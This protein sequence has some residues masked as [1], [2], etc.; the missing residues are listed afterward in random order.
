MILIDDFE[1]AINSQLDKNISKDLDQRKAV[2][3][4][5]DE[6]QFI[7]AG[8]GSGKTTV[9]ILKVLKLIF[10]D[11][12]DPSNILVT[13]FT[14]KAA[15]EL[16]SGILGWGNKLR[17]FFINSSSNSDKNFLYTLNFNKIITGTLDSISDDNLNQL[18]VPGISPPI[19]IEDFVAKA[20]MLREIFKLEVAE[21]PELEEVVKLLKEYKDGSISEKCEILLEIKDRFY[22]D[23]VNITEFSKLDNLGIDISCKLIE[24]YIGEL[25]KRN[26]TDFA[27]LESDFLSHL[28]R[29][30]LSE[31]INK[32]RFLLVDEYQDTNLL[33]EQIYFEISKIALGNGGAIT[34]VGDDDQSLYRFRGATVDLFREFPLRV[35]S[36]L[37]IRPQIIHLSRNYRSTP[38][39]VKFC[40]KYILLDKEFQNARVIDKRRIK[41]ARKSFN[42]YP[43][44]GLFRDD[45]RILAKDLAYYLDRIINEEG[46]KV[47]DNRG[48]E[49]LIRMAPQTVGGSPADISLICSSPRDFD[50]NNN[51][52]LPY[53]MRNELSRLKK[54]IGVFNPRG[55]NLEKIRGV[56]LLCG[57]ILECLDPGSK[58][59]K[60]IDKMPE[61][62]NQIF[63]TWRDKAQMYIDYDPDPNSPISLKEFVNAWQNRKPLGQA[64]WK[65][66]ISLIDLAYKLITWIPDIQNDVEGLVY[67]ESITRT[68]TQF[69]LFDDFD[70]KMLIYD[71]DNKNSTSSIKKAY[72]NVFTPIATNTIKIDEDLLGTLP[73]NRI[74]IMSIH[75]AK[76]LQFPLVIVDVGSD[77]KTLKSKTFKR[78]PTT[79]GKACN[80][81][82]LLRKF[83]P[84][85]EFVA[86]RSGKHRA[87]DDLIRHYF[88]AYSRPQDILLLVGLNSVRN[89][90]EIKSGKQHIPHIATG[91]TRNEDWI[92]D[93]GLK[94]L[95]HI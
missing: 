45:V 22:Y 92:W 77:I 75:Q 85:N 10:V 82:D 33:Q 18:K 65:K 40:N 90:S 39:I 53:L 7:V 72:W 23:Q 1:D 78:F 43:I 74:N 12:I 11:G 42:N 60:N 66:E 67:L 70:G 57:L 38:N 52:R 62:I 21:N 17:S 88:V 49:F 24:N 6:S 71:D 28:R 16:R 56:Q 3:A 89:G 79:G 63:E 27:N 44:L 54:P 95:I 87:I 94:N 25:R 51:P 15:L 35:Y 80:M 55:Q 31:T 2:I 30:E 8:P 26:F 86:C 14:K 68:I 61:A 83:T 32:I 81:E 64:K 9:I 41:A 5:P 69:G 48:R 76:G 84:I 73:R 37:G 36:Q 58:V 20:L 29:G 34:V 19:L 93:E 46:I 13:T 47:T 91:W 59:Q 4:S 50:K